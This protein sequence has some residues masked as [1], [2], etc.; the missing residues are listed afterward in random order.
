ME[1]DVFIEWGNGYFECGFL[2]DRFSY[3]VKLSWGRRDLLGGDV[4]DYG[5][6]FADSIVIEFADALDFEKYGPVFAVLRAFPW[7][8]IRYK[9]G[10]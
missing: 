1:P 10:A 7:K 4:K 8:I 6:R 2:P 5:G 9:Y 3:G